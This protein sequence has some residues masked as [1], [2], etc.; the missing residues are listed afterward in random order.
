MAAGGARLVLGEI[1]FAA[2]SGGQTSFRTNILADGP[3]GVG[4]VEGLALPLEGRFGPD[5][6]AIGEGCVAA[7]FR[8]LR[9][10][11]LQLGPTRLPLC[12]VGPAIVWQARGG[13]LRAGA[14]IREPRLAGRLGQ[15]PIQLAA[16]RM[17]FD[18]DGFSS[19]GLAVRLGAAGAVNRLD[20]ADL[21]GRFVS[22]GVAGSYSGL[23]GKLANIDLL[24]GEGAGRWQVRGGNLLMEGGLRVTDERV[25]VR[26]HPLLS[27]DFRL[28]L[29]DNHIHAT[30]W[31]KHPQ[32]GTRV[33]Q[34][35]VE[36]DLRTRVVRWI[37]QQDA[38]LH[39]VGIQDAD[40]RALH[41]Q[42]AWRA[43]KTN[44][45]RQIGAR[46]RYD[47]GRPARKTRLNTSPASS[48]RG[49]RAVCGASTA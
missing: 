5:G 20:V 41:D 27:D 13:P 19:S 42:R 38:A 8:A 6:L 33:S 30:G 4:R 1:D 10:E 26:F 35:T 11:G 2:G 45:P 9:I 22:W 15:S 37:S 14:E 43:V 36:H 46:L 25:P 31:L 17:R 29:I 12:P 3:V 28:T 21:G 32:S 48:V 18:L 49:I 23:T 34:A 7:S 39:V 44:Q 40:P 47:C 16:S 24:V